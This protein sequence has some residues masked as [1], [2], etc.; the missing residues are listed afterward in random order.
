M[1]Y[2]ITIRKDPVDEFGVQQSGIWACLT[3]VITHISNK[4]SPIDTILLGPVN[5]AMRLEIIKQTKTIEA[6]IPDLITTGELKEIQLPN[7]IVDIFSTEGEKVFS[8]DG[9]NT[10]INNTSNND[11]NSTK[12]FYLLLTTPT[13]Q[14]QVGPLKTKEEAD[15]ALVS[16]GQTYINKN[17]AGFSGIITNTNPGLGEWQGTGKTAKTSNNNVSIETN[18]T[19]TIL[20]IGSKG[21]SVKALQRFLNSQGENLVIDGNFGQLTKTAVLRYQNKKG[22]VVDGIVG[23]KTQEKMS[24]DIRSETVRILELPKSEEAAFIELFGIEGRYSA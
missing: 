14:S 13:G 21:D 8:N 1:G 24:A 19:S 23:P 17:I 15:N 6:Q 11:I 18:K 3:L 2:S 16:I 10:T 22:L 7:G 20:Q 4:T 5:P 12:E 9:T